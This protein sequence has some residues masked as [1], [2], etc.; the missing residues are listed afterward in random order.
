M[1]SVMGYGFNGQGQTVLRDIPV[2]L[3]ISLIACLSRKYKRLIFAN[4][5]TLITPVSCA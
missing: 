4:V 3:Q 2:C 1:I 5:P